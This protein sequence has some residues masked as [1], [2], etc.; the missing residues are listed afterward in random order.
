[1]IKE[2]PIYGDNAFAFTGYVRKMIR[3]NGYSSE[4]IENYTKEA[5]SSD[6]DH[7]VE[8]SEKQMLLIEERGN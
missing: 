8:V 7:L 3:R 1:M 4:E 2:F 5:T 6:Y